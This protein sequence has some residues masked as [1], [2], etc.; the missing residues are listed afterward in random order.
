MRVEAD[1]RK[2]HA[3]ESNLVVPQK[4]KQVE[5]RAE[6]V[7]IQERIA[8]LVFK[9][10]A[11]NEET[12]GEGVVHFLYL[13]AGMERGLDLSQH[14]THGSR[15]DAAGLRYCKQKRGHQQNAADDNAEGCYDATESHVTVS[16]SWRS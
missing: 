11:P 8:Q 7:R 9:E 4:C 14:S 15:L 13:G 5:A 2:V 3:A 6:G 1:V 10:N 12:V 16:L